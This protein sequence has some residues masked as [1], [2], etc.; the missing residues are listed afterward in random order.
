[1]TLRPVAEAPVETDAGEPSSLG[2]NGQGAC[3]IEGES[4]GHRRRGL[5]LVESTLHSMH[6]QIIAVDCS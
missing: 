6:R 4:L 2:K 3:C 5:A 1:M